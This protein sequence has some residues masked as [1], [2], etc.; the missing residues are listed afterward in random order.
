MDYLTAQ[1]PF[2]SSS[3]AT[4]Q[5]IKE[6]AKLWIEIA[7]I[8]PKDDPNTNKSMPWTLGVQSLKACDN[9]MNTP[10][11]GEMAEEFIDV[12]VYRIV[13]LLLTQAPSKLGASEGKFT[14]VVMISLIH[15]I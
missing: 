13:H 15:T 5:S 4:E 6:A 7:D 9:I 14:F 11:G 8:F 10:Q 12:Y 1:L 2:I 3:N